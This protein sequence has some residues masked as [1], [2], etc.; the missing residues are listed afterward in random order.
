MEN[1]SKGIEFR[2]LIG[3]E[4]KVLE[5]NEEFFEAAIHFIKADLKRWLKRSELEEDYIM[6]DYKLPI[7][8]GIKAAFRIDIIV[9]DYPE[10]NYRLYVIDIESEVE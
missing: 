8:F 3:F 1:I 2:K 10:E 4:E 6:H 5:E 7:E 9:V